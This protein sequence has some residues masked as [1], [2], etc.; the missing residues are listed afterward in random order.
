M[1]GLKIN[2]KISTLFSIITASK[3]GYDEAI[4]QIEIKKVEDAKLRKHIQDCQDLLNEENKIKNTLHGYIFFSCITTD[5]IKNQ[6][7]E[8]NKKLYEDE[9][10]RNPTSFLLKAIFSK[11]EKQTLSL[12][13]NEEALCNI[14]GSTVIGGCIGYFWYLSIPIMYFIKY[15]YPKE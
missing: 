11:N 8:T 9:P 3:F 13:R 12:N 10:I 14:V 1:R 6:I 2:V 4:K 5:M 15:K 7:S